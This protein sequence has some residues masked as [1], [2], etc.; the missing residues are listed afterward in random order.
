MVS[1]TYRAASRHLLAQGRDELAGG[2]VRQASEK[3]W[4]AAAQMVKAIAEQRG[5]EHRNHAALFDNI[6]RLVSATGDAE[7]RQLFRVANAL[8]INFY[9]NWDNAVNV[10]SGL[11]DMERFLDKLEPLV[12]AG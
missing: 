11:D 12:S 2:D 1:Q 9:E 5:W 7:I 3:G 8:H 10:S 4:G 6:S